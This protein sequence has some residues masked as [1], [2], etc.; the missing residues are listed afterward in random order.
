MIL[1]LKLHN[2]LEQ[3]N[4]QAVCKIGVH[5][6]RDHGYKWPIWG[7]KSR[8]SLQ[9]KQ[10]KTKAGSASSQRSPSVVLVVGQSENKLSVFSQVFLFSASQVFILKKYLACTRNYWVRTRVSKK[11][12][13]HVQKNIQEANLSGQYLDTLYNSNVKCSESTP[14]AVLGRSRYLLLVNS[15]CTYASQ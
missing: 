1:A 4:S 5:R 12:K 7:M 10:Q 13:R 15:K 9:G 8:D 6:K 3:E 11:D 14:C 2:S